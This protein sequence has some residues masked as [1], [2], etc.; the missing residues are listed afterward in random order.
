[1]P[2]ARRVSVY[3]RRQ[4]FRHFM[5]T[6]R[7]KP[8]DT[9]LDFGVSEHASAEANALEQ[10]YP[11]LDRI[12]CVGLGDG[13][14]VLAAFPGVKHVHILPS[15]PLPFTDKSFDFACSN[16]VL[17]HVGS[18]AA[19]A[20]ALN[21]LVR[22]AHRVHVTVPNRWFPIEH[23]TALPVL[24]YCPPLFRAILAHTPMRVWAESSKMDFMSKRRL[25]LV[26]PAGGTFCTQ[27]TGIRLGPFSSNIAL[28][29]R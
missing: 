3:A 29:T 15:T 6:M 24:H 18:D 1:M 16:A 19:R 22:V 5:A 13:R 17:E 9:I 10:F 21:E 14:S 11:H 23:H 20:F 12:T 25:R 4:M 26:C 27:W 28:W 8:S 2:L 7:P